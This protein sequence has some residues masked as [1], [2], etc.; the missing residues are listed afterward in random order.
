M[1]ID[2]ANPVSVQSTASYELHHIDM[3]HSGRLV[4][5]LV[6]CEQLFSPALVPD[7]KL[8]VDELVAADL[9]TAQES[10]QL[11]RVRSSIREEPN[12]DRRIDENDHAAEC[13][14]DLAGSRRRRTSRACGSD[15]RSARRR[16]YAP[17]RTNA[18]RPRRTVSVSVLAPEADLASRSRCS[19]I[20]NVFFIHI[21]MPYWYG[22]DARSA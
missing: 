22:N 15:P 12:P 6:I 19:S 11:G 16:S 4:H 8:S 1:R 13:L 21:I 10:V 14:A 18:S 20:C 2:P 5:L 7:K 17:R 9:V 3:R